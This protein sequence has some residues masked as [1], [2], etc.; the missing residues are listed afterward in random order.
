[1]TLYSNLSPLA[2]APT[3]TQIST[4]ARLTNQALVQHKKARETR[5]TPAV[6]YLTPSCSRI[7]LHHASV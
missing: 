1:M 4:R 6:G 3:Q 7:Q 2:P 5:D